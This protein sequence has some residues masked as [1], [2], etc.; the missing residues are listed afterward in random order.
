MSVAFAALLTL[1][2][3]IV[4]WTL[5][6]AL[7][8]PEKLYGFPAIVAAM[9]AYFYIVMAWAAAKDLAYLLPPG[10][11]ELGQLAALLMLCAVIAGWA[12]GMRRRRMDVTSTQSERIYDWNRLWLIGAVL[13]FAGSV[14][15]YAFLTQAEIDWKNTSAYW[16]L[17]FHVTY[18]GMALCIVARIRGRLKH[19]MERLAFIGLVAFAMF[20][21]IYS[22]RRG[23]LFPMVVVLIFLPPL[24][25][26]SKPSRVVLL[27]SLAATAVAMLAF[28]AVRPIIYRGGATLNT[29]SASAWGEAIGELTAES[30]L[31]GKTRKVSDN[32]YLYH[33]GQIFTNVELGLYQ[34]GTGYLELFVHWI[35]R[36]WWPAKPV[37]GEGWFG[38]IMEMMP[39]VLGWRM[40]VG[41]SVAGV[42]DAFNQF[43]W[44]SVLF[45]FGIAWA[46]G[47]LLDA[48]KRHDEPRWAVAYIGILCATHLLVSQGF[49]AAFVP[50]A[51]YL[52]V[53]WIAFRLC[54]PR[55][56]AVARTGA[57]RYSRIVTQASPIPPS[58]TGEGREVERAG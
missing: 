6:A 37:L 3:G 31:L 39:I 52:A 43:G 30:V 51:V 49:A 55:R 32:E 16:Y 21:H 4:M 56:Q 57:L 48:A 5:G 11:M 41:A 28:V 46:T 27:G 8:R 17:F 13:L 33:C 36:K 47:R 25:R 22:A 15:N 38:D 19:P 12:V 9:S 26:K 14:S 20:P 50:T 24:I 58:R 42:A 53:P 2:A 18:P 34:Y 23:P 35:P 44:A 29:I 45:W 7:R 54:A 10:A 40:S 1:T